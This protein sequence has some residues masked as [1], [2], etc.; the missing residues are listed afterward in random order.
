[1]PGCPVP[2]RGAA[3]AGN[4]GLGGETEAPAAYRR[5]P[6]PGSPHPAGLSLAPVATPIADPDPAAPGPG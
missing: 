1:M 6:G 5:A 2:L 3:R 4:P